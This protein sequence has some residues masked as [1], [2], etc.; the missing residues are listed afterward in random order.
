MRSELIAAGRLDNKLLDLL[1]LQTDF[2][3]IF[4]DRSLCNTVHPGDL[5]EDC[6]YTRLTSERIVHLAMMEPNPQIRAHYLHAF[7]HWFSRIVL[8]YA[9][10]VADTFKPDGS[11]NHHSGLQF[12]YGIGAIN[13]GARLINLLSHTPFAI[14]PKGHALF[15]N[16]LQLRSKFCRNWLDPLTLSGK[17]HIGASVGATPEPL[18]LMALSGTPDGSQAIDRDMAAIYLR[19]FQEKKISPTD[20]DRAA[21]KLFEQENIQPETTPQGH[22]TLG[23]S[24]AAIH[25]HKDWLLSIKG[26]SRYAYSRESGHPGYGAH[27]LTPHLGFGAIE[28]LSEMNYHEGAQYATDIRMPGFDWT[29]FA[30][31]TDVFLPCDKIFW[32]FGT[33]I[34][35]DQAL[36]GGVDAPNGT[37]VFILSLH[38]PKEIGLDSFRARKSWFFFDDTVVCLGSGIQNTLADHETG[39]TLFQDAWTHPRTFPF[40][41][42]NGNLWPAPQCLVNHQQIGFYIFPGQQLCQRRAE[43]HVARFQGGKGSRRKIQHRL[44]LP[45]QSADGRFLPLPYAHGGHGG[46]DGCPCPIHG[47]QRPV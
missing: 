13:T 33:A 32:K 1:R 41:S 27:Y 20:L 19:M 5:R 11:L 17:E 3:R 35:S 47:A 7:Q 26:Y 23:W 14:E 28:L 46:N 44:A 38:G 4:L 22:W 8:A 37:G 25:R 12:M 18:R 40:R 39:T 10:G 34:R 16:T 42:R 45:R 29:K 36:V 31:T 15:K 6:D 30:G 2:N 21:M 24:A 43:Q 9:P